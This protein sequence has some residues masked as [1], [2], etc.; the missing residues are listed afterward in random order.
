VNRH[1][2][3]ISTLV[4][5]A[6]SSIPRSR[7]LARRRRAAPTPSALR[8][9]RASRPAAVVA[10][11]DARARERVERAANRA[12]R[13]ARG[14]AT[15]RST[16]NSSNEFVSRLLFARAGVV[17]ARR[18]RRRARERCDRGVDRG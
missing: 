18:R 2:L 5:R 10:G 15:V 14:A 7:A 12:A 9:S 17:V 8:D 16:A 11:V 4:R 3:H 6:S 1:H 13:A